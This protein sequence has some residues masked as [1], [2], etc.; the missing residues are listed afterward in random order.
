MSVAQAGQV[1]DYFGLSNS[2]T[3]I[4]TE[5]VYDVIQTT[6]EVM[7]THESSKVANVSAGIHSTNILL[8]LSINRLEAVLFAGANNHL[9]R[10]ASGVSHLRTHSQRLAGISSHD[11]SVHSIDVPTNHYFLTIRSPL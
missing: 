7:G 2:G 3:N 9:S 11:S 10:L 4:C 8:P 6:R 1:S 5:L